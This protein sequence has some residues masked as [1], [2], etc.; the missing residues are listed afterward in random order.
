MVERAIAWHAD[1]IL[2]GTSARHGL[3]LFVL[4]SRAT[5]IVRVSPVPVLLV[6]SSMR[7]SL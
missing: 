3:S 7:S 5:E 2:V 4:G 1:L 6:R